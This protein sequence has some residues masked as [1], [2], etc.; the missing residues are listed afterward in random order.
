[1]GII[2]Y[3]TEQM[4]NKSDTEIINIINH[5]FNIDN[6][7]NVPTELIQLYLSNSTDIEDIIFHVH[8]CGFKYFIEHKHVFTENIHIKYLVYINMIYNEISYFKANCMEYKETNI[9]DMFIK[10]IDHILATAQSNSDLHRIQ[11]EWIAKLLNSYS[12]ELWYNRLV[13][14]IDN[15]IVKLYSDKLNI[16]N[17]KYCV[18]LCI[19]RDEI[20]FIKQD[21]QYCSESITQ[22]TYY[23]WIISTNLAIADLDHN[24]KILYINEQFALFT[25]L[26]QNELRVVMRDVMYKQF[27]KYNTTHVIGNYIKV[28]MLHLECM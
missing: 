7:C 21:Y 10:M 5:N 25:L 12:T 15:L 24:D 18:Q 4:Y 23:R 11:S 6:Y 9:D 1:M 2:G 16:N 19:I 20:S 13:K 28:C 3:Y 26:E 22:S 14:R 8:L 17:I 27:I